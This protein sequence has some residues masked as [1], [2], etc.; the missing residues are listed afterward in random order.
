VKTGASTWN[1]TGTDGADKLSNIELLQFA[2]R[3]ITLSTTPL[4]GAA[5]AS[6]ST[7][8]ITA[9]VTGG[10]DVAYASDSHPHG[11]DDFVQLIGNR[12][13]FIDHSIA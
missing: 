3:T 9:P 10:A 8:V 6:A 7:S 5:A 12:G 2:D 11:H 13:H 4:A 1:V